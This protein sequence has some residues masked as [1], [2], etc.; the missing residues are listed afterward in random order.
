VILCKKVSTILERRTY[1][2]TSIGVCF[3]V[4]IVMKLSYVKSIYRS[5]S[6]STHV[7]D[8]KH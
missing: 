8:L 7:Q 3:K 4:L 1:T 6:A 5:Y 2:Y